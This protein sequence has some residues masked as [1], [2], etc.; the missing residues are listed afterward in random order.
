MNLGK[1]SSVWHLSSRKSAIIEKR[2]NSE[3]QI[4]ELAEATDARF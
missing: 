2:I 4:E 1:N 3:R